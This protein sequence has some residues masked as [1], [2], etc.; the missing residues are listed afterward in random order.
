[1]TVPTSA[2]HRDGTA[3][4]VDLLVDGVSTTTTV[5]VGAIGSERTEITSGVEEGDT[6]VL[7]DRDEEIVSDD[8]DSSSSLT[9]LGGDTSSTTQQGGGSFGGGMG[10]PPSM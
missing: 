2:V 6:I 8:D 10:G 5:E 4:T 9:D 3:Y 1:V 7:A